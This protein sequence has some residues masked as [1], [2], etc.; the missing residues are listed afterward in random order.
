[1]LQQGVILCNGLRQWVGPAAQ[2]N[3][4]QAGQLHIA[5]ASMHAVQI[6]AITGKLTMQTD[7]DGRHQLD[8][9]LPSQVATVQP[10]TL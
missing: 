3:K 6:P 1:V 2:V 8:C 4:S 7:Y 5:Q 9:I 10:T